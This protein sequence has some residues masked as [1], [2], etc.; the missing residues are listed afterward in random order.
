MMILVAWSSKK[1]KER[2]LHGG[3]PVFISGVAFLYV[4]SL[5]AVTSTALS[6]PSAAQQICCKCC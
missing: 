6:W 3:I 1:Y 2:H 5:P 4:L